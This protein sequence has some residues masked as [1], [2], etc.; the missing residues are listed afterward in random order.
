MLDILAR[1]VRLDIL[2]DSFY[3]IFALLARDVVFIAVDVG[4]LHKS[5]PTR[6]VDMDNLHSAQ[7][8]KA[9]IVAK[10]AYRA[11]YRYAST[12]FV[13]VYGADVGNLFVGQDCIFGHTLNFDILLV[14]NYA[15][16]YR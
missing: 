10:E 5:S 1:V 11:E 9:A 7:I 3:D 15:T 12:H 2:L 14:D 16:R 6:S 13:L 8:D 4:N